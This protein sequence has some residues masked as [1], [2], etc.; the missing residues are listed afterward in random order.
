MSTW[1]GVSEFVAVAE[2]GSFTKAALRLSTSTA[3]IS[4]QVSILE[5]RLATR[6]LFRTTRKVSLTEEGALYYRDCKGVL[7]A[8][9]EAQNKVMQRTEA[10]NGLIK[11][12]APVT[13]GEKK[14]MPLLL[15]FMQRYPMI[16]LEIDLTNTQLDLVNSG[17]DFALRLGQLTDSS[18]IC[19]K[20]ATRKLIVCAAP[21]YLAQHGTPHT[22]AELSHFNCLRG[23]HDFWRFRD[24]GKEHN[25]RVKGNLR[26]NNGISLLDAAKRG[27]GLIQLP[28]Y[29]LA[30]DLASG[31][32]VRV[33][34]HYQD[35]EEGIWAL[36]SHHKLQPLRVKLLLEYL[37]QHLANER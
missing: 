2:T 31:A 20:L 8:L 23:Q 12:T 18:M 27:L 22:L 16:Q 24:K 3:N 5:E 32:L 13:Y 4:R 1:Q 34:T 35:M 33:L 30:D 15:D 28:D 14:V 9:G 25:V 17:C 29:Y 36:F 10:P 7:D 21:S 19:K 6:L 37:A 26:C 11:I